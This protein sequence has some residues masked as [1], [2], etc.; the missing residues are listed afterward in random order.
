MPST[1][2]SLNSNLTRLNGNCRLVF[3]PEWTPIVASSG[4]SD[5]IKAIFQINHVLAEAAS[6]SFPTPSLMRN[7]SKLESWASILGN[8]KV[9]QIKD[10]NYYKLG[11]TLYLHQSN[12][13]SDE[14][15]F[16]AK[17][18]EKISTFS[19]NVFNSPPLQYSI[20]V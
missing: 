10:H 18:S 20:T 6:A 9:L 5:V 4:Y 2:R 7:K 15:I 8:E 19:I 13:L 11:L 17:F 16:L 3:D 14:S 1:F 12:I